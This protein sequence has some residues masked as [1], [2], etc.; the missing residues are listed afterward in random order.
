M[1]AKRPATIRAGLA[2]A[3]ERPLAQL[4]ASLPKTAGP[5]PFEPIHDAR[6]AL[7]RLA[8][9]LRAAAP[10][11]PAARAAALKR[12]IR[13]LRR[14]LGPARDLDVFIH[15]T[16]PALH[17]LFRHEAGLAALLETARQRR[18]RVA[19]QLAKV[20]PSP[21]ARRLVALL[22]A[23]V[24]AKGARPRRAAQAAG[25]PPSPDA[26]FGA[27]VAAV[28]R[29]RWKKIARVRR[30]T[31]LPMPQ[32][33]AL[34]IR[35]R[36]FRYLCDGFAT[37]LPERRY[38]AFRRAMT[39]LQ[40]H[41]GALNDASVAPPLAAALAREAALGHD[42]AAVARAAGLFAGWG[43]ARREVFHDALDE[44]WQRM[45]KR[46]ERMFAALKD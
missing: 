37:A 22:R 17:A 45:V 1:A 40:D 42:R 25:L 39:A 16:M 13:W 23:A 18:R 4:A 12:E 10:Y 6:V 19:A 28:L 32:L 33:H 35:L 29:R 7:R 36:N 11:L 26:P 21:R 34:R 43:A 8:A 24:P 5:A 46:G 14:A 44:P 41:L 3:T 20:A 27:F 2:A 38:A 30:L 15:E 31:K 9:L